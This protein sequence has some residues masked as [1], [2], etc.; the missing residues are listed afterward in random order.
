MKGPK[1]YA[2]NFRQRESKLTSMGVDNSALSL[3]PSTSRL[4]ANLYLQPSTN[5]DRR[6]DVLLRY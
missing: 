6:M 1:H 2:R 3:V 4:S 5:R